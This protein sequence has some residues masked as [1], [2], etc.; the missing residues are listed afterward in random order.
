MKFKIALSAL[1]L[2]LALVLPLEFVGHTL[3]SPAIV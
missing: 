2:A 3:T 1:L